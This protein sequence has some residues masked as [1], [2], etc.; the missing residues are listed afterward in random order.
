MGNNDDIY[1]RLERCL[2]KGSTEENPI[3]PDQEDIV[4]LMELVDEVWL[5]IAD[6]YGSEMTNRDAEAVIMQMVMVYLG[7]MCAMYDPQDSLKDVLV[8]LD[9]IDVNCKDLVDE[10]LED[11][12]NSECP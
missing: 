3:N 12:G 8:L 2:A 4:K 5:M 6:K 11:K 1:K 7:S 9:D 10:I